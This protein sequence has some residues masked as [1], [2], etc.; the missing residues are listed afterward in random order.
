MYQIIGSVL[1]PTINKDEF[2]SYLWSIVH[3]HQGV[4]FSHTTSGYSRFIT[5]FEYNL[6]TEEKGVIEVMHTMITDGAIEHG[7]QSS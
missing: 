2:E 7:G 6:Q 4:T 5:K 3:S 1:V